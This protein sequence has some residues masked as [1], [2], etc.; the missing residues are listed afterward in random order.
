MT[1]LVLIMVVKYVT[2][3][4]NMLVIPFNVPGVVL[5]VL[6]KNHEFTYDKNA[7]AAASVS[8]VHKYISCG[9][10]KKGND[11][12][13]AFHNDSIDVSEMQTHALRK[14]DALL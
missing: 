5:I 14:T 11:W 6:S 8:F 7:G 4:S 9:I 1:I 2:C 12:F 3:A 13:K 10:D